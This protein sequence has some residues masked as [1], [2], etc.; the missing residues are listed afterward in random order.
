MTRVSE[1]RLGLGVYA[2]QPLAP[3]QLIL[4]G[5]GEPVPSRTRH[6]IQID[7][8][9]HIIV[10]SPIQLLN[11]S[12]DPNCG[13]LV[14][15]GAEHL[16]VHAL[17]RIEPGEELTIDY[18]TF[19]REILF[20]EPP[21]LCNAASCRGEIIGYEGLPASRR[22]ALGSFIAEYL[23]DPHANPSAHPGGAR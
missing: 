2:T 6:S 15:R 16:E 14:P 10:D 3:G 17:R 1:G 9:L 22:E 19:E 11:H 8:N 7:E 18:A 4:E 21:C 13:L 23:R 5:R 12:C 20:M